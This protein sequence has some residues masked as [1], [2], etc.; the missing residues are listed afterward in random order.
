MVSDSRE[1]A[2]KNGQRDQ[3]LL[4]HA[5]QEEAAEPW[6]RPGDTPADQ[7]QRVQ[8]HHI[9]RG[10]RG[11]GEG[12]QGRRVPARGPSSSAE[13]GDSGTGAAGSRRLG[14]W[15]ATQVP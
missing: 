5:H 4:E 6:H 10:G 13:G 12:R 15:E 14:P 7:R 8:H 2:R 11:G 9:I 3:E 1:V